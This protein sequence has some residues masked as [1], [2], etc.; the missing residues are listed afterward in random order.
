MATAC[1]KV[2]GKICSTELIGALQENGVAGADA[3]FVVGKLSDSDGYVAVRSEN[4]SWGSVYDV[5]RPRFC[6]SLMEPLSCR[7]DEINKFVSVFG[8]KVYVTGLENLHSAISPASGV[9]QAGADPLIDLLSQYLVYAAATGHAEIVQASL[10]D[11]ICWIRND[12]NT[13][14]IFQQQLLGNG[15]PKEFA[16]ILNNG[17]QSSGVSVAVT[18]RLQDLF[19]QAWRNT[20]VQARTATAETLEAVRRDIIVPSL[21]RGKALNQQFV[22][23]GRLLTATA[24]QARDAA[25]SMPPLIKAAIVVGVAALLAGAAVYYHFNVKD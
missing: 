10:E 19:F 24:L 12:A 13:R 20:G 4:E 21:E 23:S 3:Q 7:W 6:S 8:E 15:S 25:N 1:K 5:L 14:R 9:M 16:R 11:A 22:A 2:D 18:E 17:W